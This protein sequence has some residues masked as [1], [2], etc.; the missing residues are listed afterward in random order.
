MRPD[1]RRGPVRGGTLAL[2][3]PQPVVARILELTGVGQVIPVY[4]T[5]R[6]ARV[7]D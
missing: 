3:S 1:L 7:A 6:D 2:A 4:G 5:L